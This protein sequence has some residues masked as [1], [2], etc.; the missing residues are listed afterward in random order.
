MLKFQIISILVNIFGRIFIL[1]KIFEKSGFSSTF[2][3]MLILVKI[4]GKYQFWSKCSIISISVKNF[5]N[6]DLEKN[7]D[8]NFDFAKFSIISLFFENLK[9]NKSVFFRFSKNLDFSLR[10]RK[11]LLLSKISEI[12]SFFHYF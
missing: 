3:K 6:H 9:K 5:R 10:I 2:L 1:V 7:F 11:Y 8:E 4:F 12:I